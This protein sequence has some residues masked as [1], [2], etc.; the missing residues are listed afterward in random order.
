MER[1][2]IKLALLTIAVASAFYWSRLL[3]TGG[4]PMVMTV[5]L[6]WAV[7]AL[8]AL[9]SPRAEDWTYRFSSFFG[10]ALFTMEGMAGFW[11]LPTQPS[12]LGMAAL[13]LTAFVLAVTG[14][15]QKVAARRPN[16]L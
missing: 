14:R 2:K 1:L 7:L 9:R 13:H 8:A 5:C 4:G 12:L 6:F 10:I 15:Y 16:R 11:A 3:T